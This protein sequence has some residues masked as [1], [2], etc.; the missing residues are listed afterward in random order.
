MVSDTRRQHSLL[1][2][3]VQDTLANDVVAASDITVQ[4]L[5]SLLIPLK[6]IIIATNTDRPKVGLV[7]NENA[8]YKLRLVITIPRAMYTDL[9]KLIGTVSGSESTWTQLSQQTDAATNRLKELTMPIAVMELYLLISL[10]KRLYNWKPVIIRKID[11]YAKSKM[12]DIH[13]LVNINTSITPSLLVKELTETSSVSEELVLADSFGER[14]KVY[15]KSE[16]EYIGRQVLYG[17]IERLIRDLYVH[18]ILV[19]SDILTE[20]AQAKAPVDFEQI[21]RILDLTKVVNFEEILQGKL[22]YIEFAEKVLRMIIDYLSDLLNEQKPVDAPHNANQNIGSSCSTGTCQQTDESSNEGQTSAQGEEQGEGKE[23]W[24]TN[25][26]VVEGIRYYMES[27][28]VLFVDMQSSLLS[29]VDVEANISTQLSVIETY[30][31]E[32]MKG[33]GSLQG[34][35]DIGEPTPFDISWFKKLKSYTVR[36]MLVDKKRNEV[37]FTDINRL[38]YQHSVTQKVLMPALKDRVKEYHVIVTVDE[39]GSMSN[40]ELRYINYLIKE[41]NKFAH[42]YLIKHDY[43]VVFEKYLKPRSKETLDLVKQRH[44]AGGTSHAPVFKKIEEYWYTK[45][46]IKTRGKVAIIICSDF[47]SDLEEVFAEYKDITLHPKVIVVCVAPTT[48]EAEAAISCIREAYGIIPANF[49]IVTIR[50]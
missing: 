50:Q 49:R 12:H 38:L 9:S 17:A 34:L 42:I 47:Y 32:K 40:E 44:A 28:D 21:A 29:N 25:D 11:E 2:S 22:S 46:L 26:A 7:Y 27:V 39:S 37:T 8:R 3:V 48:N 41:A 20:R 36:D 4:F 16:L 19:N 23:T 14:L 1:L 43:D 24:E 5:L 6:P 33:V 35:I 18:I 30:I 13:N 31:K 45:K 10:L 15:S